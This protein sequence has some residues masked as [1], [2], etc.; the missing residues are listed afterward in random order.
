M[1]TFLDI[2]ALLDSGSTKCSIPRNVVPRKFIRRLDYNTQIT[3]FDNSKIRLTDALLD[4]V[5]IQ[6]YDLAGNFGEKYVHTM[7]VGT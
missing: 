7:H 6:L 3:I 4:S 5:C 2:P 1:K